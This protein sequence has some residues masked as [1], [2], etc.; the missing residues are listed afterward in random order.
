MK[1][2]FL[3]IDGVL[4]SRAFMTRMHKAGKKFTLFDDLDFDAVKVLNDVVKK[5][6]AKVVLSST[7]RRH[8]SITWM[9]SI[10]ARHGFEGPL[11]DFTPTEVDLPTPLPPF[12][13]PQRGHEIQDWL[14]RHPEVTHFVIID[15]DSDMAHLKHKLVQTSF[16]DGLLPKH[17]EAIEKHLL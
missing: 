10:L 16:D 1:I 5:T 9:R 3:D 12:E 2:I 7:W 15:D 11:I 14:T 6:G 17:I 4:N 8:H 13:Y